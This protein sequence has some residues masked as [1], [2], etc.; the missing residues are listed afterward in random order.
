MNKII[1]II[2]VA[3]ILVL[4]AVL[5]FKLFSDN[6]KLEDKNKQLEKEK[7][8]NVEDTKKKTEAKESF[9]TGSGVNDFNAT[10]DVLSKLK[11]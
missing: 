11:D 4:F 1:G 8:Q 6:K 9:E 2:L 5:M 3:I 7:E 10:L